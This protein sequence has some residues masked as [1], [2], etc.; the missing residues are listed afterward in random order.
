MW[1]LFS[2]FFPLHFLYIWFLLF[3]LY[4]FGDPCFLERW[5]K[6][7]KL[8]VTASLIG[9][10]VAGIWYDRWRHGLK[11]QNADIYWCARF[12]LSWIE[13][14]TGTR[15]DVVTL[16]RGMALVN[17][18]KGFTSCVGKSDWDSG[19]V[20]TFSTP[21]RGISWEGRRQRVACWHEQ[22]HEGSSRGFQGQRGGQPLFIKR[23]FCCDLSLKPDVV[24]QRDE[25][26][27]ISMYGLL[28][29]HLDSFTHL[30]FISFHQF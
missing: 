23:R 1:T 19:R 18:T 4:F 25:M 22:Q 3:V 21:L 27:M 10:N 9:T 12:W 26:T 20:S 15:S 14:I 28:F 13:T 29:H 30:H 6:I 17:C 11:Q 16:S 8:R 5:E 2:L 7:F 24:C